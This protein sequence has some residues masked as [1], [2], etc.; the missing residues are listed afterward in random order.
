MVN[1]IAITPGAHRLFDWMP[2]RLLLTI[3]RRRLT[4][5]WALGFLA[6][7]AALAAALWSYNL[8]DPSPF[9][10]TTQP[11]LNW[12][13]TPGAMIS[14]LV[15]RYVGLGGWA[16]VAFLVVWGARGDC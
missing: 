10:A 2:E 11:A 8:G 4:E 9:S 6:L 3:M 15:V 7:A 1:R 5:I 12:L 13:G 14:D 16:L